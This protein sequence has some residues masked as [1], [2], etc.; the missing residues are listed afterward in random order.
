MQPYLVESMTYPDGKKVETVPTPLRRI[1][2]E[3]TSK[4]ITAML[5]DGVK[6]GFARDGSVPGYTIAGKTGTSQIPS[7]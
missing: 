3:S 1:I 7:K 5:V 4:Q 6:Y 2:K